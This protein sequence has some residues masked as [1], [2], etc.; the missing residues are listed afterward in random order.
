[1]NGFNGHLDHKPDPYIFIQNH[2]IFRYLAFSF[3]TWSDVGLSNY[4]RADNYS[5]VC[6]AILFGVWIYIFVKSF[7]GVVKNKNINDYM[8]AMILYQTAFI[9]FSFLALPQILEYSSR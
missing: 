1:M 8:L 7:Q 4:T 5:F 9:V 2:G 3:W 6:F